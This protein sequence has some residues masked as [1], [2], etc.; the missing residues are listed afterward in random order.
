MII[1]VD[2]NWAYI[3]ELLPGCHRHLCAVLDVEEARSIAGI[4]PIE[5]LAIPAHYPLY[6][7]DG[8]GGYRLL[9]GLLPLY[10]ELLRRAGHSATL[11]LLPRPTLL[12]PVIDAR[13]RLDQREAVASILRGCRGYVRAATGY[14]KS[15]VIATLMKYFEARRLIV[16]PTVRLLYQMAE[17]VQEW[18]GLSPG[19]VGDGNDDIRAMTIATVD[20]LYERIKRGD[21]RY[22]EWLS[23]I[24]IAVFDEAHTYMNA[25]GI[26]T[27]LSL[28][29]VHYKI[30]MTATPKSKKMMEAIFGP[31]LG[32]YQETTLI[33][34]GVI[35]QPK[36]EFYPA[37]PG[38]VAH[39]SFN[40]PFTPWLYNQLYDSV[41]V[42]NRARNAL[43]AKHACRLIKDG[44]GPVLI[45]V[46]KVGT[47]SKKKNPAS[48]ALNVL[49]ELEA[50]GTSLPI[51]HGKS[52]N[53]TDV[54]DQLSAGSIPGAIASEGILSLGVSIRSIGSI[55]MAAG[56]KGGVDG[57]SMIQ[58]V[59]RALRVKEGKR[60]PPIIDF[61]DP[62]GWFHSQSKA[63]IRIATDTYGADNV[64]VFAT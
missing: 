16:V 40:K 37:P 26:T 7:P 44:Y 63:R 22:I 1:R 56:G 5:P 55:I 18:A 57:V 2:G 9:A 11:E 49:T 51:I 54:L 19:L 15:A 14:G 42:N 23:S 28:V 41:I 48:Q 45:L 39:G 6:Y 17:D 10:M 29:N 34:S 38:A 24:E 12:N 35:M 50:L 47:T 20:T 25:S 61:V 36:F 53:I 62:Q 59:G 32:E 30:G 4:L 27:A 60:N 52:T 13:L 46:R 31:L 3:P 43:I 64:T 8:Q 58:K 33:E 21:K